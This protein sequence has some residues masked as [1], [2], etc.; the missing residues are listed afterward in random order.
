[1]SESPSRAGVLIERFGAVA[2]PAKPHRMS[3]RAYREMFDADPVTV[4]VLYADDKRAR[5]VV[6]G[7]L[8][9]RG[10]LTGLRS[11]AVW[12]IEWTRPDGPGPP[13]FPGELVERAARIRG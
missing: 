6:A 9:A 8:S 3:Q 7:P 10:L 2:V 11:G 12:L 13:R 4:W 1:M 5:F